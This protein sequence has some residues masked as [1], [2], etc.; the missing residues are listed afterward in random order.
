MSVKV[1][2][3]GLLNVVFLPVAGKECVHSIAPSLVARSTS[4]FLTVFGSCVI[5]EELDN[6]VTESCMQSCCCLERRPVD[7]VR[8][9]KIRA[10]SNA[11]V[12]V[13]PLIDLRENFNF[14]HFA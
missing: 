9:R 2:L 3:L 12:A 11:F 4:K 8:A 1:Q 5:W 6:D 13:F 10:E 7:P 14:T